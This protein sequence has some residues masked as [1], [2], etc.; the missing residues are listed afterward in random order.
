MMLWG[1]SD[2]EVKEKP[3]LDGRRKVKIVMQRNGVVITVQAVLKTD[4]KNRTLKLY[5]NNKNWIEAERAR[6][7]RKYKRLYVGTGKANSDY[8]K[9]WAARYP[10]KFQAI[11]RSSV[12]IKP[13]TG[14][15]K[16]HWSYN[17]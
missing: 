2:Q 13:S 11:K 17:D 8:N 6:G 16:H 12:L 4:S 9:I 10:E 1:P 14:L 15:E 3:D 7:R 5:D